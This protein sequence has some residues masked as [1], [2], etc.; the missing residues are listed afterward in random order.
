MWLSARYF[1]GISL[2]VAPFLIK[3]RLKVKF[4]FIA[5]TI[6]TILILASVFYW[7]IFPVC[8][9]EGVGLTVFK[10]VSE[11]IICFML[12]G[13][14][15]MLLRKHSEFEPGILRLLIASITV[16]IA[17]ELAFTLYIDVTGFFNL[18]G[19]YFKIISFYLIYKAIIETGFKKTLN[20]LFR[21]I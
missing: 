8:F 1:E 16:T 20:L 17:S 21:D 7:R 9:V 3:R 13:S 14:V 5:Y 2:L 12:F 18:I 11:Y 4:V 6:A 10:K 15:V 19:H